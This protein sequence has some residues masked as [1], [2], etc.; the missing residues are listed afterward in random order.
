MP[1]GHTKC[2]IVSGDESSIILEKFLCR[3]EGESIKDMG[4]Q[5]TVG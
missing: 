2:S 4:C 5:A 3:T 1:G